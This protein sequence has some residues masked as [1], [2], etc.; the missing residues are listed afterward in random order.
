MNNEEN[1]EIIEYDNHEI[2]G[3]WNDLKSLIEEIEPDMNKILR[4][5]G[6]NASIRVRNRLSQIKRL[7]LRI[8][9]GIQYQR[10]D[11]K[12]EY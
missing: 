1:E 9:Q 10:Q 7:C 6:V 5:K 4:E 2:R 3:D 11:N 12:S 8:R